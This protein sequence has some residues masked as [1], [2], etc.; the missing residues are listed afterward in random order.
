MS[1]EIEQETIPP[2]SKD[3]IMCDI[4]GSYVAKLSLKLDGK[5][6]NLCQPDAY[7]I[8]RLGCTIQPEAMSKVIAFVEEQVYG[9]EV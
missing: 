7:T 9:K 6:I 1:N 4:C 8:L 2:T 5:K 3:R